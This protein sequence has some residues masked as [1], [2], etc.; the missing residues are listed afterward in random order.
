MPAIFAIPTVLGAIGMTLHRVV[1]W[2]QRHLVF[3][4]ETRDDH[5]AGV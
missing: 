1:R 5:L 4:N 3:W 2:L